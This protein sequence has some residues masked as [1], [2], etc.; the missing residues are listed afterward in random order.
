MSTSNPKSIAPSHVPDPP[1]DILF[2]CSTNLSKEAL[3]RIGR[4]GPGPLALHFLTHMHNATFGDAGWHRKAGHSELSCAFDLALWSRALECNRSNLLKTRDHLV[5]SGAILWQPGHFPGTGVLTWQFDTPWTAY[6]RRTAKRQANIVQFHTKETQL[7]T[8]AFDETE[9][10]TL[11]QSDVTKLST[12]SETELSVPALEVSAGVAPLDPLIK[13]YVNKGYEEEEYPFGVAH[14]TQGKLLSSGMT[15]PELKA[16][17]PPAH[18]STTAGYA[19]EKKA[20]ARDPLW[21]ASVQIFGFTPQ[22][23]DERGAWNKALK[24]LRAAE[25][26]DSE[27]KRLCAEAWPN[28]FKGATLTINAIAKYLGRLRAYLTKGATNG[29]ADELGWNVFT[30]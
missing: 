13:V 9:L 1:E 5:E 11:V 14:A 20:R 23:D 29:Q 2:S 15:D 18:K 24:Q 30:L 26:T 22:T 6:H 27:L 7:T 19:K 28:V 21:D 3:D 25:V 4:F 8:V 10:S 12:L 16:V 17:V